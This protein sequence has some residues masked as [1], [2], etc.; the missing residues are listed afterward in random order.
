[1]RLVRNRRADLVNLGQIDA[2]GFERP[3][4]SAVAAAPAAP[5]IFMRVDKD[6]DTVARAGEVKP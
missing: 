1:M 6:L 3:A 5:D 2:N 4:G